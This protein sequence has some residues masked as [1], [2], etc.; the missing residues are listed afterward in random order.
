MGK[1]QE[2]NYGGI[3]SIGVTFSLALACVNEK[4]L[5]FSSQAIGEKLHEGAQDCVSRI[6]PIPEQ[7]GPIVM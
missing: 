5:L 4:T 1:F 7:N 2:Y 3:H 6:A